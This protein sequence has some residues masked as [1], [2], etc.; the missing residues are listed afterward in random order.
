VFVVDTNVL[1]YVGN[2]Q[3]PRHGVARG[4]RESW[5]SGPH[6]LYVTWGIVYEFLRV[7]THRA[8]FPRPLTF[9]EALSLRC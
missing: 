8:V 5:L 2:S 3:S 1:L 6:A 9:L 4:L 7:A